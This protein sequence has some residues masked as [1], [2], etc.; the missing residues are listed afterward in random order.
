MS[1]QRQGDF[2]FYFAHFSYPS[3]RV[4]FVDIAC[5][6]GAWIGLIIDSEAPLVCG[7]L[8]KCSRG[9]IFIFQ[10]SLPLKEQTKHHLN[11]IIIYK[12][13]RLSRSIT[14]SYTSH[15]HNRSHISLNASTN[16]LTFLLQSKCVKDIKSAAWVRNKF[17]FIIKE[18]W[19]VSLY[20]SSIYLQ[21]RQWLKVHRYN[22]NV[23]VV[24]TYWIIFKILKLQKRFIT[25]YNEKFNYWQSRL[26]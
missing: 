5:S 8:Q 21:D 13:D 18:S 20:R 17:I 3:W 26:V 9:L 22:K 6:S 1:P 15:I 12:L 16:I 25:T 23:I 24:K 4:F 10:H 11:T 2:I 19:K 7:F 14:F